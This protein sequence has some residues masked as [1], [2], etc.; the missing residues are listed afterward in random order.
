MPDK[1]IQLPIRNLATSFRKRLLNRLVAMWTAIGPRAHGPGRLL[2]GQ[3]LEGVE[4]EH[5]E[6]F[7]THLRFQAFKGHLQQ[8]SFPF[9]IP[10]GV[11]LESS[12]VGD[13]VYGGGG[14]LVVGGLWVMVNRGSGA[15]GARELVALAE[16]VGNPPTSLLPRP[17]LE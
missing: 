15:G 7:D 12:R 1:R 11:S 10:G 16:L 5:L 17:G 4:V 14:G 2:C 3:T 6:L 9:G 13:A 8:V